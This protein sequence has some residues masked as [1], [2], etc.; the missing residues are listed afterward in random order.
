MTRRLFLI[1][2]AMSLLTLPAAAADKSIKVLI[3]TGDHGHAWK[4]TT[5]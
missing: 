4:E 2:A 5:P 1:A 3:I